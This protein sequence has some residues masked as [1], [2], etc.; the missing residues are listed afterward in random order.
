MAVFALHLN[1]SPSSR[2]RTRSASAAA[3]PT[4]HHRAP[5][6]TVM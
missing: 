1:L 2:V 5:S 4:G 6:P 3:H